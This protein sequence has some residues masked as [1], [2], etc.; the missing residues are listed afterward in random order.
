M[1][2]FDRMLL[3]TDGTVTTLLEACTGEPVATRTTRQAGPATLD[4]LLAATGRWWHP[5]AGLLELASAE[6]LIARRSILT[7]A[8][9]GVPYMLAESLVVPGRLPGAYAERL[10]RAGASLGRLLHADALE[11]RREVLQIVAVRAGAASDALGVA[12]S[13]TLARRTYRIV[14][15]GRAGAAVTEWLPTGRLAT[16]ARGHS[17]VSA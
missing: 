17:E 5:D 11:A 6:H 13:A 15:R 3:S 16:T 10:T 7:G 2:P 4:L 1:D 14:I 8:R 12:S 9:S